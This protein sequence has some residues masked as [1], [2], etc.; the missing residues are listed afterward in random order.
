MLSSAFDGIQSMLA[1][2]LNQI[3]SRSGIA[4]KRCVGA[5]SLMIAAI[6]VKCV[7]RPYMAVQINSRA[8]FS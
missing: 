7:N 3:N 6:E 1:R 8:A 4:T 5:P 2:W